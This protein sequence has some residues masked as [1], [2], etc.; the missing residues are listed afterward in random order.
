MEDR[1]A[2][3]AHPLDTLFRPRSIAVV[4]ASASPTKLGFQMLRALG[5]SQAG[6]IRS[7]RAQ[8][9]LLATRSIRE[10]TDVPAPI[11]LAILVVSAQATPAALAACADAG[12][13]PR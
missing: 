4:G 8:P 11:D 2:A 1:A 13:A 5:R 10:I 12:C 6:C 7:T 3:L 9:A